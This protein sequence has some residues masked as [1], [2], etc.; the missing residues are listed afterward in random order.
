MILGKILKTK[1]GIWLFLNQGEATMILRR[2][3][4]LTIVTFL[5]SSNVYPQFSRGIVQEG[6]TIKSKVLT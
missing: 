5:F 1:H 6:L 3:T 2:N 4:L